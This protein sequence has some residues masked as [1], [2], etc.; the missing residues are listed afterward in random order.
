M[1]AKNIFIK[2]EVLGENVIFS[3]IVEITI[4][5]TDFFWLA[6][7]GILSL[8]PHTLQNAGE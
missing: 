5:W 7:L 6:F 1:K 4:D 2:I 3:N 8:S